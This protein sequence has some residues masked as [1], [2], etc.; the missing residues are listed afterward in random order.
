MMKNTIWP[1]ASLVLWPKMRTPW[2]DSSLKL[3]V[4][5]AMPQSCSF[6]CFEGHYHI[7]AV[8]AAA[9]G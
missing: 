6:V 5:E 3:P 4:P 2:T 8:L 9:E 7:G 1:F